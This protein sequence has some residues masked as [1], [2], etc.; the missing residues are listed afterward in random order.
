MQTNLSQM[1]NPAF[2]A[3][4]FASATVGADSVEKKHTDRQMGLREP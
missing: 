4:S 2:E 3:V 1:Q